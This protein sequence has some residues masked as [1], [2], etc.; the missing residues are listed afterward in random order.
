MKE[1]AND[2]QIKPTIGITI[3]DINGIGPEV[4]MKAV[5]NNKMLSFANI[6]IYGHGKVFS[7]YKN[8]LQIDRFSF[9]QAQSIKDIRHNKLNVINCWDEDYEIKAGQETSEAGRFALA[10]LTHASEDLKNGDIQGVVTAPISK[11]NIQADDFKFPGHTE[12]FTETFGAEDSLMFLCNES[13]KIGVAT[14]H[15]PLAKVKEKLTAEVLTRKISLMIKSLKKDFGIG[16]PRVAI[17]GLNPHA[18]E[19]GLLGSEENEVITPVI[20][21]FKEKGDLVFGPYPADG[22]FGNASYSKFDGVLAMYHD[23]GLIPFKTI[24]FEDGVNFTAGLPIVR[25]SPDHG[26][27]FGIAGKNIANEQSMRSAL[28]MAIDIVRNR[29]SS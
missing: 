18:G 15:I 20:S 1:E 22:F 2:N 24:A 25:T 19:E 8:H 14:G 17:L 11:N 5:E 27:A 13:L 3:G 7:F 9:H 16:K 29:T 6:V 21:Q 23:Q 12:Y 28:Y 26:T 10:S 4:V